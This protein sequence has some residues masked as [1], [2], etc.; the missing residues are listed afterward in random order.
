MRRGF[1]AA[2]VAARA[3]PGRVSSRATMSARGDFIF[4]EVFAV[5]SWA[6]R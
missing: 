5:T 6:V 4:G 2:G 3:K 1:G